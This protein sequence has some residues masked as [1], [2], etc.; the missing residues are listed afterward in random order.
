[1]LLVYILVTIT[2][3]LA[4][5]FFV[6]VVVEMLERGALGVALELYSREPRLSW[7]AGLF[8][9]LTESVVLLLMTCR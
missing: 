9:S 7:L 8:L 3:I 4:L 6:E 2:V 5:D 1:M